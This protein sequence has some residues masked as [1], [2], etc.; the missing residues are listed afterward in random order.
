VII[1]RSSHVRHHGRDA[2]GSSC[3]PSF[4]IFFLA[5]IPSMNTLCTRVMKTQ[6]EAPSQ[7]TVQQCRSASAWQR[8]LAA[9]FIPIGLLRRADDPWRAPAFR[10]RGL[11]VLSTIVFRE[12]KP[13]MATTSPRQ[14]IVASPQESPSRPRLQYPDVRIEPDRESINKSSRRVRRTYPIVCARRRCMSDDMLKR[15][16]V[17]EFWRTVS[18]ET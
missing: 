16:R 9:L 1:A 15:V 5:A 18:C 12:L 13:M 4:R 10:A 6:H 14:V 11:T 2:V 17:A 7:A 8:S 3:S